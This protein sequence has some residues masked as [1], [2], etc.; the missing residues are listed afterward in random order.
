MSVS[1]TKMLKRTNDVGA[2]LIQGFS[3]V[4]ALDLAQNVT[5]KHACTAGGMEVLV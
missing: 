4:F 1:Y 3:I 5:Y 2:D